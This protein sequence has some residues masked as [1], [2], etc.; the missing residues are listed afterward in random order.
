MCFL[1]LHVLLRIAGSIY[2]L[3]T[4]ESIFANAYFMSQ[5]SST[6][7]CRDDSCTSIARN[8]RKTANYL[9]N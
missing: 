9:N 2:G 3:D 7:V 4:L 5:T 1:Q 8:K 6:D